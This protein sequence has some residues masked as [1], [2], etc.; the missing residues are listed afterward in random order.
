MGG[1]S[2]QWLSGLRTMDR[3]LG[4]ELLESVLHDFNGL[5]LRVCDPS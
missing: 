4:L 1:E 5:F 2:A 3:S